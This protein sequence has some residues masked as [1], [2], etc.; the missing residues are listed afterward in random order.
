MVFQ[1]VLTTVPWMDPAAARLPGI[2]P[3]AVSDWIPRD[4]A[5]AGQMAL[6]DGLIARR[7]GDV[8]GALATAA[9]AVAECLALMVDHLRHDGGYGRSGNLLRRPDGVSVRVD[10]MPLSVIGRLSQSDICLMEKDARGRWCLTAAALCFPASWRLSEK[11]GRDLP[12]LHRPV[13]EYDDGLARRVTRL[14]DGI[15]V[16]QPLWR[17]NW[18][19]Y[20]DPSLYQPRNEDDPRRAP[21]TGQGRYL[22]SERQSL[23]RLPETGAVVFGIHTTVMP[24]D[25]L[26][27]DA[28]AA[29]ASEGQAPRH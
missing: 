24:L 8:L 26:P 11:L 1:T 19:V 16:E 20:D 5:F 4:D 22:R 2:Q 18:M 3:L 25:R 27:D 28:R 7:P 6:R 29:L 10:G 21:S 9:P 17:A 14:F 13:S 15:R 23:R 12:G